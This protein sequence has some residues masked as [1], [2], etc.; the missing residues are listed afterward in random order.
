MVDRYCAT[1]VRWRSLEHLWLVREIEHFLA[2]GCHPNSITV[3]KN[4]NLIPFTLLFQ[5]ATRG[6][7]D[8]SIPAM[9]IPNAPVVTEH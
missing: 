8:D 2:V 7:G 6:P 9:R 5:F 4:F 1:E 3:D